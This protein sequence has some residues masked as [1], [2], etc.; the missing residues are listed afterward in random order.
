[1]ALLDFLKRKKEVEKAKQK[2][3][4]KAEKASVKPVKKE[5]EKKLE[6]KPAAAKSSG[7]AKKGSFSYDAIKDPH[8][9]EKSTFLAE[10]NQYTFKVLPRYNKNEIRKAVEGIYGVDVLS[11][12]L[13]K[14]PPKKRRL[15]KTQGF[16][17]GMVKAVVK[18][19]EGQKIEIL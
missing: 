17:N 19:K 8:I 6:K 7:V 13:V 18:I 4:K 2:P 16:K 11:V 10:K 9:S 15:G 5:T 1:M 12:N 3:V 14:I